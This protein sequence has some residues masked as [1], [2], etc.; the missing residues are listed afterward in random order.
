MRP[1]TQDRTTLNLAS[2]PLPPL[3]PPPPQEP[4][5]HIG[6]I[7]GPMEE[8]FPGLDDGDGKIADTG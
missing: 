1:G 8:L 6:H 4:V 5:S 2:S 3:P 7:G